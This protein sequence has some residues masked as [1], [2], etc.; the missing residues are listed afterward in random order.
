MK[1]MKMSKE[2]QFDTK[3]GKEWIRGLLFEREVKITFI[4][5]DGEKREMRCTLN[6][7]LMRKNATPDL[8]E[9][10]GVGRKSSDDAQAV[11]D[12]DKLSWRSFRFDSVKQVDF[13]IE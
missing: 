13:T 11:F 7:E 5:K 9:V 8:Y 3:K 1:R 12:L 10:K 6:E 4:K 2:N